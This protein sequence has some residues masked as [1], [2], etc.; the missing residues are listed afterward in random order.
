MNATV[1]RSLSESE[2]LL[3]R[4]EKVIPGCAQTFSKSPTSFVRGVAP[5]FLCDGQG[6]WVRDLD[7]NRYIDYI[8]GLGP[9]ILGHADPVVT[10][11]VREAIGHGVS[12]SL[13]HPLET[14][15]AELLCEVIPCAE[16]VRFGK[17]G[18]DA[19][20]AAV[21]VARAFTRREKVACCGYHGWQ[22]W[23]IGTTDRHRGVPGAVRAL[24]LAFP[25]ND[26]EAL[27]RLFHGHRDEIACVIME[28]VT[29]E[30]PSPG[31]LENVKELCA[32]N[33]TLLVFDEV[34]TGFRIAL[35]GAQEYFGVIPDLACVGKAMANGFPLSALVGRA[36]IMRLFEEVFFSFTFG[37]ETASLAACRATISELR[38]RN[39]I[40]QLRAAGTR[41]ASGTR[42]MIARHGL[43]GTLGCC[44][45]PAYSA[46]RFPDESHGG[47]ILRSLFQQ[48]LLKRDILTFGNHMLSL[49]H[50]DEIIDRTL[51]AY[52]ETLE[53]IARAVRAGDAASRLEGQPLRLALRK[54]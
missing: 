48:E 44:G 46:I 1:R 6:A 29:F 27:E 40:A 45:L 54:A 23:Y 52:G 2:G 32:A 34:V 36:D 3:R 11:A 53:I 16:M 25:Y 19:T 47:V 22:D 31:Y 43:T 37:G 20:A 39:G 12:Y 21:R 15:V 49:S 33:G 51:A 10:E 7:G 18:S 14:E 17:N 41:L 9:V 8:M 28:P 13:P 4:T 42:S 35:G 30:L 26:I 38:R 24:T 50:D 5:A